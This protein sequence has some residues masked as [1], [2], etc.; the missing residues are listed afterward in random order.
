MNEWRASIPDEVKAKFEL[1]NYNYA[2]EILTRSYAREFSELMG[3]LVGFTIITADLMAGGGNESAVPKKFSAILRPLDWNEMRIQGDLH[4]KLFKR[5]QTTPAESIDIPDFI[6][7]HNIDY[8]KNRVAF[9]MEWNSKD[10]TFDRDLYAFRA[11][12]ECGIIAGGVIV[13]RS[14]ELNRIFW[15]CKS[16]IN[17]APAQRG[18]ENC[19]R[20]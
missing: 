6:G 8:V 18:W 12:H 2:V 11:F 14:E 15:P 10:Q 4:V 20:G 1:H 3:A 7:G 16:A 5:G 13:T 17:T 19:C 9:D